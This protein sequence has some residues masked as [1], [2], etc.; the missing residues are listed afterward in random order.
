MKPKEWFWCGAVVSVLAMFI[1]LQTMQ[2]PYDAG[3]AGGVCALMAVIFL[4][5]GLRADAREKSAAESGRLAEEQKR[6]EAQQ[7]AY[8][9]VL[10]QMRE[11]AESDRTR[12]EESVTAIRELLLAQNTA[13]CEILKKQGESSTEY[14]KFMR[15]QAWTDIGVLKDQGE[16]SIKYYKFMLDQPCKDIMGLSKMLES[17]ANQL[18]DISSRVDSIPSGMDKQINEQLQKVLDVLKGNDSSLQ[19]MMKN[20]CKT[21]ENQGRENKEA[22]ERV[23][24]GYADVTAQDLEVLTA[25]AKDARV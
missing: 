20:V 4:G 15:D 7:Q 14:Y 19:K 1:L 17:I 11:C 22:M 16:T 10:N 6:A 2:S 8:I 18:A 9:D 24:Q 21:L 3:I 23:I 25:L 12:I 13:I 5:C